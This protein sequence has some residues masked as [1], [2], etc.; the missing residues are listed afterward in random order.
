MEDILKDCYSCVDNNTMSCDLCDRYPEIIA[1]LHKLDSERF[2]KSHKRRKH[3]NIIKE[4]T[5]VLKDKND[6]EQTK[7]VLHEAQNS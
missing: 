6:P 7:K 4:T 5:K 3:R 2:D 1:K